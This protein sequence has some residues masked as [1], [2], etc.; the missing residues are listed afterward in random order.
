MTLHRICAHCG[1]TFA[2]LVPPQES[3]DFAEVENS[4]EHVSACFDCDPFGQIDAMAHFRIDR[5]E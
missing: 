4:G 5:G 3:A 2:Y 1:I